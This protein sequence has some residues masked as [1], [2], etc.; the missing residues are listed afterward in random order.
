MSEPIPDHECTFE[1]IEVTPKLLAKPC[2]VCG[3]P[4]PTLDCEDE[5]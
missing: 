1:V 2:P 4:A 5:R 3:D